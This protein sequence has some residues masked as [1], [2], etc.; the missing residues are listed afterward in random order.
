MKLK[1]DNLLSNFAFNLNLRRP[2]SKAVRKMLNRTMSGAWDCW[3][4]KYLEWR[5]YVMPKLKLAAGRMLNR[6]VAVVFITWH[7]NVRA[8]V[9]ARQVGRHR[10]TPGTTR[11]TAV[12][13]S[14]AFSS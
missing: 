9:E 13:P 4:G 14:L 11:L 6:V 8:V 7:G 3:K 1:Y 5:D 2:S 10:F 12:D